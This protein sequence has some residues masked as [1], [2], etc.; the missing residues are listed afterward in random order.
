[1]RFAKKILLLV[2]F[3]VF[4]TFI[5]SARLVKAEAC[6]DL[7]GQE[8]IDCLTNEVNRLTEQSRTLSNQIAQFNAQIYL[9]TL[10]IQQTEEKIL[11]LGGR[12]D[13]L[14]VSLTSLSN[15]FSQRAIETY[16]MTRVGDPVLLLVSAPNLGEAV[17]RFHYLARIQ[18]A[19]RELMQKLQVAQNNYKVDKTSQETLQTELELQ[20][21][22]LDSQKKDKA[23]LLVIT[24]NDEKTYQALL[25]KALAEQ[26]AIKSAISNALEL[27]KNGGGDPVSAG[28]AIALIGNSGAPNCSTGAHLHF[29]ILKD[30]NIQNPADYLKNIPVGWENQPDGPFGFSGDWDWP[31]SSPSITQGF[32]MTYWARL[33]WYRGNIHDGIDIVSSASDV[34]KAPKGG[35]IIRGATSCGG[36][37]LKY[38]AIAH[39]GGVISVYLHIQ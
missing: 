29:S 7:S 21:A 10:K 9:T 22:N 3:I 32:G 1:M 8:K 24:K 38:A 5:L 12:I 6:Q 14:E 30:G 16:K 36:S 39:D 2:I 34:I 25:A 17:S 27:L 33:G 13:Q 28:D 4:P 20:K 26:V 18:E 23:A 31:V 15:A 35:K 11:L 19:D 37:T